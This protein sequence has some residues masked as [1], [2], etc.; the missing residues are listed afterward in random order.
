MIDDLAG[1]LTARFGASGLRRTEGAEDLPLPP[2]QIALLRDCGIPR[3]VGPY[4]TTADGDPVRLG[5]YAERLDCELTGDQ[6]ASWYR[7]GSDRGAEICL[8]ESGAVRAAFIG[9]GMSGA[10]I[11]ESLP[12]FLE[13][14][15]ALDEALSLIAAAKSVPE[16]ASHIRILL[17]QLANVEVETVQSGDTWWSRVLEDIRH[18]ASH[19]AYAAFEITDARGEQQIVTKSGALCVH[20]EERLWSELRAAGVSSS[21]VKKVHTE[22]QPC[23]M[24]GHYCSLWMATEFPEAEFT[25]N[26]DY[27]STAESREQG[28]VELL[29]HA[30]SSRG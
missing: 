1:R 7:I 26:F 30:A 22:L 11:N 15:I 4:F 29:R 3:Q 19:S 27:G 8:D 5:A 28:F 23:F 25:H 20:P 24:P 9:L 13:S 6:Q 16:S 17:K 18:T 2:E 14:L 12:L 21:Q 10:F